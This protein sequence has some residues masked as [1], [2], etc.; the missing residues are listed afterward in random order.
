MNCRLSNVPSNVSAL[1]SSETNDYGVTCAI[2]GKPI[3]HR[4]RTIIIPKLDYNFI[5]ASVSDYP[6]QIALYHHWVAWKKFFFFSLRDDDGRKPWI[7][8]TR[9]LL[10][11]YN[12]NIF[13][14]EFY[15]NNL[16]TV[17]TT[18]YSVSLN[19]NRM[20]EDRIAFSHA[21]PG[22]NSTMAY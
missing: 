1:L 17:K 4:W 20:S 7:L 13:E 10:T 8:N 15:N 3:K 14:L 18:Y 5:W 16:Y 6:L 9:I 22:S 2:H 11:L 21:V 19:S 12:D